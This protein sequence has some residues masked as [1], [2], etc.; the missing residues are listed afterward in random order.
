MCQYLLKTFMVSAKQQQLLKR[1]SGGRFRHKPE[2]IRIHLVNMFHT[3]TTNLCTIILNTWYNL[4]QSRKIHLPT[5]FSFFT[6]PFF[7]EMYLYAVLFCMFWL[8]MIHILKT[9]TDIV[10]WFKWAI[11]RTF[12]PLK[13]HM[14]PFIELGLHK[15]NNPS[16]W[17]FW[18]NTDWGVMRCCHSA[19]T[20]YHIPQ[21]PVWQQHRN[22]IV[23]FI[24]MLL[25]QMNYV[26][27]DMWE[28]WSPW[29]CRTHTYAWQ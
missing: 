29:E 7:A 5:N 21:P 24:Q 10:W 2:E 9:F 4:R 18:L 12:V 11:I 6:S 15:L 19:G 20:S 27:A 17:T 16:V 23:S 25:L 28:T 13:P 1:H 14:A 3:R 8:Q 22:T 26:C